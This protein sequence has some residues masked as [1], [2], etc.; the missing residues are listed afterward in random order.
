MSNVAEKHNAYQAEYMRKKRASANDVKIP[1]CKNPKR[2]RKCE[3]DAKL[4]LTTYLDG[5]FTKEFS[6][7]QEEIIEDLE[8]KIEHGEMKCV[9][10]DRGGGKTTIGKGMLLR[11]IMTGKIRFAFGV[12]S[13]STKANEEFIKPLILTLET[14]KKL[15]QDYPEVCVPFVAIQ[16]KALRASSQTV[17]GKKTHINIT[18]GIVFPTVPGSKCSGSVFKADGITSAAR[19][20]QH[21][22]A[23]GDLIRPDFLLFDDPQT[24]ESAASETQ[25]KKREKIVTGMI[26]MAGPGEKMGGYMACTVIEHGDLSSRFLDRKRHPEWYGRKYQMVNKWPKCKDTLW[27]EYME[28]RKEDM[29]RDDK[30]FSTSM[31]FYRENFDEM[32]EGAEVA[33]EGRKQEDDLTAIQ[34]AFHLVIKVGGWITFMAEY[35]ND[36]IKQEESLYDISPELVASRVNGLSRYEVPEDATMLV[37]MADINYVGLNVAVIAFR[38]DFTGWIVDHFKYPEGNKVLVK[39]NTPSTEV[40]KIVARAVLDVEKLLDEKAYVQGG[41]SI[42]IDRKL[43]DGNYWTEHVM[44]ALRSMRKPRSVLADRGRA[45]TKYYV[46]RDKSKIIGKPYHR[47]HME[48]GP[49]GRQ[50]VHDADY[51]RMTAQKAFLLPPGVP[52]SL[53][54]WGT[55]KTTHIEYGREVCGEKLAM[56]VPGEPCDLYKWNLVPGQPN[57]KLDATVGCYVAASSLGASLDGVSQPKRRRKRRPPREKP[58]STIRTKY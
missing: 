38:N 10:M 44:N 33:W 41:E 32:N 57:D 23:E 49:K 53:S 34:S 58:K 2:R 22:T 46:P 19:G 43:F 14:N 27:E 26:G 56:Y 17:E 8:Y 47:C 29:E 52:G 16:G 7:N 28:L 12:T 51:W 25:T 21:T 37:S 31:A 35:Q 54:L 48:N 11:G 4:W 36:P 6:D 30:E 55:S 5:W 20:A 9:A 18:N 50:I 13:T 1:K 39:K 24:D 45:S 15:I 42:P 40:A 3:K